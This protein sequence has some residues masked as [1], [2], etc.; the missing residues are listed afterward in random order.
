MQF[1]DFATSFKEIFN[2]ILIVICILLLV[3]SNYLI[4][5][6]A[7]KMLLLRTILEIYKSYDK[8]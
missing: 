2:C 3:F 4:N 1:H 5:F 6:I 8:L 7:L